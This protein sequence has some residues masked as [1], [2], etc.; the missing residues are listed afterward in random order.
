MRSF[1]D[2]ADFKQ[3]LEHVVAIGEALHEVTML[4]KR[5]QAMHTYVKYA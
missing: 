5:T 4:L 1:K 3:Q 2:E